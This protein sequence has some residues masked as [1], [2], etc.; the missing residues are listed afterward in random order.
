MDELVDLLLGE[1]LAFD[2]GGLAF[3]C[4]AD[5]VREALLG[6]FVVLDGRVGLTRDVGAEDAV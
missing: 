4:L 1:L 5:G 3:Y 6:F 2:Y